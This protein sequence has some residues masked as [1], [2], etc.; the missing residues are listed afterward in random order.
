[1]RDRRDCRD[2]DD[3]E[4]GLDGVSIQTIFVVGLTA[5]VTASRSVMSQASA[6]MPHG[7]NSSRSW[8][9]VP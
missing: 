5:R 8:R 2:V 7:P 1:M 3:A 6:S 9:N 4:R